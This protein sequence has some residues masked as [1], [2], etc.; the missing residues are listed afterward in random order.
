MIR[1]YEVPVP[2]LEIQREIVRV[3]DSFAELEAR[4]QQY[5]YYRDKLLSTEN[6]SRMD[7]NQ[8]ELNRLGDICSI[9]DGDHSAPLKSADGI[10]FV[11]IT[12]VK[13]GHI[14]LDV[15]RHVNKNYYDSLAI[16]CRTQKGTFSM[17]LSVRLAKL[18]P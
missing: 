2:P 9:Y 11:T 13:N 10:P 18:H 14:N 6:L 12:D 8:A 15:S 17:R 5:T 3:L 16:G 4:R 1:N 7:G